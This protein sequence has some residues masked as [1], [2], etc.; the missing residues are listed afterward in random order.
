MENPTNS[1]IS[2]NDLL[3]KQNQMLAEILHILKQHEQKEFRNHLITF[4]AHAIPYI[5][6][7]LLGYYIYTVLQGYLDALN[8]NI[9]ILRDSYLNLQ[10]SITNLIPDFS[11]I[12][13][14]LQSTWQ[15]VKSVF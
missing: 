12:G 7:V 4:I 11:G 3:K 15:N 14:K 5:A 2:T 10:Q 9:T 8:H 6:I 13:D 1:P